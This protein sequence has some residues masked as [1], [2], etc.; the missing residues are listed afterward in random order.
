LEHLLLFR[1][2]NGC[3]NAPQCYVIR[4][5]SLLF[6]CH[7]KKHSLSQHIYKFSKLPVSALL[8]SHHQA[9]LFIQSRLAK[10]YP[11]ISRSFRIYGIKF[12]QIYEV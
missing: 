5:L 1:N 3:T 4:R 9:F 2:N 6:K 8:T 7:I 11:F 12:N 10:M